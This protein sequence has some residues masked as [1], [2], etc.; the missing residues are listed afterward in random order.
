MRQ[1][2]VFRWCHF[3]AD[4][5]IQL[6]VF[7]RSVNSAVPQKDDDKNDGQNYGKTNEN[8]EQHAAFVGQVIIVALQ[9]LMHTSNEF[10]L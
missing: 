9:C 7:D 6:L 8:V 5:T 1:Y 4:Q 2:L 10:K 3:A